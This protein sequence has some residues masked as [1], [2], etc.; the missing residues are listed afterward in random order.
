MPERELTDEPITERR[1]KPRRAASGVIRLTIVGDDPLQFQG[2]LV[3]I[4]ESGFRVRH[5]QTKLHAGQEVDFEHDRG[6][7]SARVM[8]TRILG[9]RVE[10]GFVLIRVG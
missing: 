1:R 3:N 2:E 8:W 10:S 6:Q 9:E 7:G 4:S 5:H